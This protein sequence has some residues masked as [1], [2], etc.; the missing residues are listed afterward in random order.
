ML[1]RHAYMQVLL[2]LLL[3]V[4]VQ[5]NSQVHAAN[6]HLFDVPHIPA[7]CDCEQFHLTQHIGDV[8][9]RG[10]ARALL[11][12]WQTT[13]KSSENPVDYGLLLISNHV[14]APPHLST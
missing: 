14:R 12:C 11:S 4:M 1:F 13:P 6:H 8:F 5:A 9:F 10:T 7:S 3:L 2:S